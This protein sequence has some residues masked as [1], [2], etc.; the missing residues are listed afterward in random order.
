[1]GN[2]GD[3]PAE[4]LEVGRLRGGGD[5]VDALIRLGEEIERL[6][7]RSGV[8]IAELL[9]WETGNAMANAALSSTCRST[10]G[11]SVRPAARAARQR[12]SPAMIS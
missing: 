2:P 1:M 7:E 11:T 10:T 9:R 12:R 5:D 8:S 4:D 6:V 3:Q